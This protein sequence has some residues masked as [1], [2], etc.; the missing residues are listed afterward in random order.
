MAWQ[1][2]AAAERYVVAA[3]QQLEGDTAQLEV[4]TWLAQVANAE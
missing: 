4:A 2:D 3:A 1:V